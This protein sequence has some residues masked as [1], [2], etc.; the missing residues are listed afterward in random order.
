MTP[1]SV[2]SKLWR[3]A[4]D[5]HLYVIL[6]GAQNENLLDVFDD[7]PDL[8]YECLFTQ[9]LEPDMAEVA[10]YLVELHEGEAFTKWLFEQGW[11]HNWGI[12]VIT[13]GDLG[14][15]WRHLRQHVRVYGPDRSRLYFRYY[16]PR[17]LHAFLPTCQG[18]QLAD[19]FG[20]VEMFVAENEGGAGARIYARA[21]GQLVTEVIEAS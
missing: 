10:P 2:R 20:P 6:D 21:D 11:G 5:K 15:A 9:R 16:D 8:E 7:H 19:F 4:A 17:V 12:F 1:E 14:D 13:A 3:E 18:P